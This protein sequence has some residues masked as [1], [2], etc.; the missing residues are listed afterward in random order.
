MIIGSSLQISPWLSK[1][2]IFSCHHIKHLELIFILLKQLVYD[3]LRNCLYAQRQEKLYS[4]KG[5]NEESTKLEVVWTKFKFLSEPN[6]T[7]VWDIAL[8]FSVL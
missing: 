1:H 2:M 4:I 5:Q 8:N 7:T 6:L 3:F